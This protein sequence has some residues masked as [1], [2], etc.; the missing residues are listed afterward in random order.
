MTR[1]LVEAI[2]K[3]SGVLL[4]GGN[5]EAQPQRQKS[6]GPEGSVMACSQ[7]LICWQAQLCL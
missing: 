6:S 7:P 2:P 4:Y 3:I 1:M 5:D